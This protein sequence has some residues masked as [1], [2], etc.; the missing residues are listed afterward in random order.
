MPQTT[1]LAF[2]EARGQF[3][4]VDSEMRRDVGEYRRQRANPELTMIGDGR[5]MFAA[6]MCREAHVASGL[7]RHRIAILTERSGE[8]APGEI[9]R[10]RIRRR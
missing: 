8:L 2:E 1:G 10:S 4:A 3:R 9:A 5:M 7:P 6:L